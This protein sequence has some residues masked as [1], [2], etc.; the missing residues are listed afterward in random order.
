MLVLYY[1][2]SICALNCTAS[3]IWCCHSCM[4][5]NRHFNQW[6]VD[7]EGAG[8]FFCFYLDA[9]DQKFKFFQQGLIS[10]HSRFDMIK[11]TYLCVYCWSLHCLTKSVVE[12]YSYPVQ[13]IPVPALSSLKS[14]NIQ[15]KK[16]KLSLI[17]E[18]IVDIL[19]ISMSRY[20][21]GDD[22]FKMN[23]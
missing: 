11:F 10:K 5:M 22:Y 2:C 19:Y 16:L 12:T 6:R 14:D 8:L 15:M 20:I 4:M 18:V 21:V 13:K 17:N 23:F 7:D 1:F 3:E 9:I